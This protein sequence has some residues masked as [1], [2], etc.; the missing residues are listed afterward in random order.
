MNHKLLADLCAASYNDYTF[1][2]GD[3]E[4]LHRETETHHIYAIRGTEMS[5]FFSGRGW[6]DVIRDIAIWP[7]SHGNTHGHAGFVHG[8]HEIE[9]KLILHYYHQIGKGALKPMILTG[10][11]LGGAI[12]VAG[13]YKLKLDREREI[14]MVECVTFGAPPSLDV[15]EMTEAMR[16]HMIGATTQYAHVSDPVP[17]TLKYTA[18]D[19]IDLEYIGGRFVR[20]WFMRRMSKHGIEVYQDI[21]S[22]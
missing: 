12:A 2:E 5:D 21:L 11:S 19:H 16:G 18:Y 9:D 7:K 6:M 8:W 13:A 20:P 3:V 17:H 10:H 15:G 4:V 14:P 1:K 22:T